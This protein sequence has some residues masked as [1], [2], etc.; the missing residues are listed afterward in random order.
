MVRSCRRLAAASGVAAALA[1]GVPA[2]ASSSGVAE[3]F[4]APRS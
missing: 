2:S 1:V 4:R 3:L